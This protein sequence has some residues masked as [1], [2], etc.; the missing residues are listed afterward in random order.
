[1]CGT[2]ASWHLS[3]VFARLLQ[4]WITPFGAPQRATFDG[5]GEF[6]REFSQELDDMA[7]RLM[8][9]SAATPQ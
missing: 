9:T 3:V 2:V 8:T 1:M 5:G 6:E 7:C 4:I